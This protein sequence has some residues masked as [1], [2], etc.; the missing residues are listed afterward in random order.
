MKRMKRMKRKKKYCP[1]YEALRTVLCSVY[2][3]LARHSHPDQVVQLEKQPV[4]HNVEI[5][6]SLFAAQFRVKPSCHPI[7][8][9]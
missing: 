5:D 6:Q 4:C 1:K 9:V 7:T 3:A 8:V 2:S